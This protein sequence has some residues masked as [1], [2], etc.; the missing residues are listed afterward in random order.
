MSDFPEQLL[1]YDELPPERQEALR[2]A[3]Q[4]DPELARAFRR[5][6]AA[7][8]RV[9]KRF[10][11]DLP[12]RRL[13]VHYAL[14]EEVL[15]E[16]ER[17]EMEDARSQIEQALQAHPALETIIEH[18]RR[19]Q[20]DFEEV[21]EEEV[22][23][24]RVK[25]TNGFP[26][27]PRSARPADSRP[28]RPWKQRRGQRW[29]W[30]AAAAVSVLA[31][32]VIVFFL[33]QRNWNTVTVVAEGETPRRV[34]LADG[35]SVRLMPGATL[36]YV[37]PEADASFERQA[38]LEAGRAFFE[39]AQAKEGFILE[40]PTAQVMVLGTRFGITTSERETEVVLASGEVALA[41][42][43]AG[44]QVVMLQP[45]QKSRVAAGARPTTPVAV[46]SLADALGWTE[47]FFFRD[48]PAHAVAER[49]SAYY[50]VTV[51]I[52][53]PLADK[54]VTGTFA[55]ERPLHET[56][57]TLAT[58]LDAEVQSTGSG[59]RLAPAGER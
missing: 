24:Q 12:P 18:I 51:D 30:R 17:R 13:L 3:L 48:T 54:K 31:F 1:F 29:A 47:L 55:Q 52:A 25:R 15:S 53:P 37:D 2:A 59:F 21:W 49:L 14:G 26:A 7:R 32:A 19:E 39:I 44:E 46:E 11:E 45:G 43:G 10:R 4:D 9:A 33:L 38:T 23:R 36:S 56:L 5:W 34:E 50:E 6:Q 40:T 57:T 20:A 58:A 28:A 41:P 35:S 42:K 16:A 22:E 8:A 27:E